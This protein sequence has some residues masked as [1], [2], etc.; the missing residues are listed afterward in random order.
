MDTSRWIHV[1]ARGSTHP[2][3]SSVLKDKV[4]VAR[5]GQYPTCH[6]QIYHQLRE[7]HAR[8]N[9]N[10]ETGDGARNH[11]STTQI[12]IKRNQCKYTKNSLSISV[13]YL[14]L[15]LYRQLIKGW[16]APVKIAKPSKLIFLLR[17][18]LSIATLRREKLSLINTGT[19][20]FTLRQSRRRP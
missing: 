10:R 2:E 3:P 15:T 20:C 1:V 6:P 8:Y 16:R 18:E 17:S 14:L 12:H 19:A 9:W 13:S 7:V 5:V 4:S 11:S